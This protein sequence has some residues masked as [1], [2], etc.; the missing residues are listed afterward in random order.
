MPRANSTCTWVGKR[1]GWSS[2][3][4]IPLELL[5][6]AS[7]E[8]SFDICRGGEA[9]CLRV[10][11]AGMPANGNMSWSRRRHMPERVAERFRE[12]AV[13]A[14]RAVVDAVACVAC[15]SQGTAR[16]LLPD[17]S[18]DPGTSAPQGAK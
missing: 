15:P 1:A 6:E 10:Y 5:P 2:I 18:F 9:P 3:I 4:R 11:F 7:A 16:S 17:H 14:R 8:M 13:N 12:V